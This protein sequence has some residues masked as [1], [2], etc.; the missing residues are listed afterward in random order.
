V[1]LWFDL[2]C[3]HSFY[4]KIK[5]N[6]YIKLHYDHG[7]TEWKNKRLN[8]YASINS[9][10]LLQNLSFKLGVAHLGKTCHTDNRLKVDLKGKNEM[11]YYWYHRTMITKDKC[12]FGFLSVADLSK[13]FFYHVGKKVLQKNNFFLS[14]AH[15]D[16]HTVFLRTEVNGFRN[17]NPQLDQPMGFFDKVLL[18]YVVNIDEKSKAAVEVIF[19]SNSACI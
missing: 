10:K 5:S 11:E 2:P 9:N 17:K 4:A 12:K 8:I 14:Y 6:D 7:I 1:K 19:C 16:K 18:N 13:Y 3:S 15:D